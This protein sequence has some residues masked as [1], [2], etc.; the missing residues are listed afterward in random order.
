MFK[1]I[2]PPGKEEGRI[3][4]GLGY[5]WVQGDRR[6]LH[7]RYIITISSVECIDPCKKRENT[8]FYEYRYLPQMLSPESPKIYTSVES[9]LFFSVSF[10]IYMLRRR[11]Q[12]SH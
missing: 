7:E 12:V 11:R 4:N 8:L 9:S 3:T 10:L 6:Q 2:N 5:H 1:V